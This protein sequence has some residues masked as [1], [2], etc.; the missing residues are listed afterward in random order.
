MLYGAHLGERGGFEG[1]IPAELL[2]V[3]MLFGGPALAF[4]YPINI[5]V[6]ESLSIGTILSCALLLTLV[7]PVTLLT[8]LIHGGT[9]LVQKGDF[10]P[11]IKS[12]REKLYGRIF[13]AD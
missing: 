11:W 13:E 12:W 10:G 1:L 3:I 2:G 4:A 9:D 8:I 5:L 6:T 7:L